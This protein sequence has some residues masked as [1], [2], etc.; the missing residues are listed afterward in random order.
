MTS[1]VVNY[2]QV[3][4][5]VY[6]YKL[7]SGL[8]IIIIPKP[9][10]EKT[11]V[12]FGTKYGSLTNKFVPYG[13]EEYVDFPLGIAHFLEHQMFATKDGDV[14]LK[15]TDLGLE[16][17]AYTGWLETV[18]LFK[19]AD[20]ILDGINLL[21]DFVQ[22][23]Y[24]IEE[25]IESERNIIIQE[26]KMYLDKPGVALENG[27]TNNMFALY[28][29]KYDVG[30]T[31]EEVKKITGEMLYKCHQTFYHPSNMTLIVV[32]DVKCEDI[33]ETVVKNQE[34]KVILPKKDIR[35]IIPVEDNVVRRRTGSKKM[36]VVMPKVCVGLKLPYEKRIENESI[37]TEVLLKIVLEIYFSDSTEFYQM[38]LDENIIS[39]GLSFSVN[40][41][42][43]AGFISISANT[44]KPEQ[45]KQLIKERL[46]SLPNFEFPADEFE[47][48]KK[49]FLGNFIRSLNSVDYI[50]TTYFEYKVRNSNVFEIAAM[51]N[52]LTVEEAKKMSKYFIVD[53]LTDYTIKPLKN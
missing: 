30:G 22:T 8:E 36:D 25:N 7:D 27:I 11:F 4:E 14:A 42:D 41:D 5:T 3:G 46:I 26:L 49:A 53:A 50:A 24:F 29:I 2:Q 31:I 40:V 38:L 9:K 44:E 6:Q 17:N 13:Q 28:P 51:I 32:G 39:G 35:R 43:M 23:P 21:L 48:L 18:Y 16:V 12:C 19:G 34:N 33:V 10:F 1:N 52:N 45:F 15:F 20:H 37:L 47:I